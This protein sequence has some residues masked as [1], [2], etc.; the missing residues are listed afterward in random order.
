MNDDVYFV[1]GHLADREPIKIPNTNKFLNLS[2]E[3]TVSY[4]RQL[5]AA[6]I[7]TQK[8]DTLLKYFRGDIKDYTLNPRNKNIYLLTQSNDYNILE[9][10]FVTDQVSI[11]KGNVGY[12]E[13]FRFFSNGYDYAFIKR[14]NNGFKNIFANISGVEKQIT[15]YPGAINDFN[16]SPDDNYITFSANRRDEIQ[17]WIIKLN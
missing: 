14:D 9:Y 8:V 16:I 2:W 5:L 10:N 15:S 12:I 1:N 4:T 6:D 7:I 11:F 13:N 17:S 3:D